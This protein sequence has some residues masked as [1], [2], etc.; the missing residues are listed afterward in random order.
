MEQT[1]VHDLTAAY[2]LDALDRDEE[3]R[4]EEH[5]GACARCRDELAA[6]REAAS[7]LAYA[8]DAPAPPSA[9]RGRI[10]AEATRERPNVIPLG[11]RWVGPALATSTAVAATAAVLLAVWAS[12]LN[13][14]L[15]REQTLNASQQSAL[16]ILADPRSRR[17]PLEG[18][19]GALVVD[20]RGRA[21]LAVLGLARA[22][23]GKTYEAWVN[24][25]G[26]PKPAGTFP[27]GEDGAVVRLTRPVGR[28]TRVLVTIEAEGGVERPT[29]QPILSAPPA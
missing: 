8:V 12:S 14:R 24:E 4:Y 13:G 7:A 11:R 5:L 19:E 28:Q 9:L 21:A 18:A 6:L 15:D 1:E 16:T 25:G 29:G 22:P 10:L 26:E 23:K 20:R 27:G 2:A 17:V 3:L